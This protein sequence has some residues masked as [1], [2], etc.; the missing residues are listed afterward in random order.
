[1]ALERARLHKVVG[2]FI[3]LFLSCGATA[4]ST[5]FGDTLDL[6]DYGGKV[7]I[8]HFWASWST[9]SRRAFPWLAAMQEKYADQGLIIV[10][11]NED[12]NESDALA[13]LQEF[14][15]NFPNVRDADAE[16]F[17]TYDLIAMPSSYV[18]DRDGQVVARHLGFTPAQTSEIEATVR[19][20]LTRRAT[21]LDQV[22][23]KPDAAA[24]Q[25]ALSTNT[26]PVEGAAISATIESKVTKIRGNTTRF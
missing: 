12:D 4:E 1:M 13:F 15:V 23:R 26:A 6:E 22:T 3:L 18:I 2:C 14:Q 8:V 24:A 20:L 21:A 16:L 5:A 19:Q 17:Q 25:S 11:V 9:P 7:V 10:G